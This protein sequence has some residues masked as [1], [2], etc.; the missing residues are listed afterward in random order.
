MRINGYESL[1]EW[2]TEKHRDHSQTGIRTLN[3]LL[4]THS[5]VNVNGYKT[6]QYYISLTYNGLNKHGST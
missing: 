1:Y 3:I 6:L 2:Q 5:F 4:R